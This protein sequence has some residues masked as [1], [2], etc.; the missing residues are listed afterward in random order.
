MQELPSNG[1]MYRVMS[2]YKSIQE[3]IKNEPRINIAAY[4]GLKQ[5][6]LSGAQLA[7]ENVIKSLSENGILSIQLKVSHAFHSELMKP[8]AEL[9]YKIVEKVKFNVPKLPIGST[10]TGK[11]VGNEML[12]PNYWSEQI[13]QSVK[14]QQASET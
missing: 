3:F 9:F 12:S 14:F 13:L 6:V 10:V 4:N 1:V 8:A 2:D 5:T 11:I 7:V